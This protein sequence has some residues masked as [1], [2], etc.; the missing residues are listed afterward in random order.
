MGTF[1]VVQCHTDLL[2]VVDTFRP[3]GGLASSLHGGQN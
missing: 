3:T 2:E 1:V